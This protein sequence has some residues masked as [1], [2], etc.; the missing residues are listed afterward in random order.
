MNT[1]WSTVL[2]A[3]CL[4][5]MALA[6]GRAAHADSV[7]GGGTV[8]TPAVD[9]SFSVSAESGKGGHV[10][11]SYGTAHLQYAVTQVIPFFTGQIIVRAVVAHSTDPS[12]FPVNRPD[13]FT[14]QDG[15]FPR[16]GDAF[17][18]SGL[19]DGGTLHRLTSGNIR[20]RH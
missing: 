15:R 10:T 7:T 6:S 3:L 2:A 17:A 4:T 16:G 18:W 20:I 11:V 9:L 13:E 14:F 19:G 8:S 5:V 1:R 12:R